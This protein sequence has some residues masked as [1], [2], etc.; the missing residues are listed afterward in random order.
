MHIF[1]NSGRRLHL[2]TGVL[3]LLFAGNVLA[4]SLCC[5]FDSDAPAIGVEAEDAV[6][7]HG[8]GSHGQASDDSEDEADKCAFCV[9]V[10]AS[11]DSLNFP[12]V[13]WH[14]DDTS[15]PRLIISQRRETLYRP[16]INHLS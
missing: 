8:Q 4:T 1:R 5:T 6:P 2:L 13:T 16:P 7:C 15:A 3:L 11:S 9:S 10:M 12:P 14:A